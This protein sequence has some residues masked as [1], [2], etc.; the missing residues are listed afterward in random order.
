MPNNEL[1]ILPNLFVIFK[2][3][4]SFVRPN[5]HAYSRR[6][7]IG[8]QASYC[9]AAIN[10]LKTFCRHIMFDFRIGRENFPNLWFKENFFCVFSAKSN[11][12]PISIHL[13]DLYGHMTYG[14]SKIFVGDAILRTLTSNY[15]K[16]WRYYYVF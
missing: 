10:L 1:N 16:P 7:I 6:S 11:I 8:N 4:Y 14:L 15:K 9:A 5:E 2:I 12:K 13:R 3:Q